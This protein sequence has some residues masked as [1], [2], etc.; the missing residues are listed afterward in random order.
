M[1]PALWV[2]TS[3]LPPLR[4]RN[5]AYGIR[6]ATYGYGIRHAS[7]RYGIHHAGGYGISHAG[8]HTALVGLSLGFT[9]RHG[10]LAR[11][12]HKGRLS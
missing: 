8:Y 9:G 6:H 3:R 4:I 2:P 11:A 1:A 7:Y 12:G 5:Y 10:G